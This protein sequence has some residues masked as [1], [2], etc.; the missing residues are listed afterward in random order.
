M[1][2]GQLLIA[3]WR[4]SLSSLLSLFLA[5]VTLGVH[6]MPAFAA[7]IR[8]PQFSSD[9]ASLFF[10]ICSPGKWCVIHV[11]NFETGDLGY[12]QPPPGKFW[13]QASPSKTGH[14]VVFTETPADDGKRNFYDLQLADVQIGI[15]N[16]DGSGR[17]ILT[18]TTGYKQ[19]PNFSRS[20]NQVLFNQAGVIHE[21]GRT[22]IT[23]W[24]LWEV[25]VD[26][27]AI[28]MFA[29]PFEFYVAQ[30]SY[31]VD[32]GPEVL[33]NANGPLAQF[34]ARNENISEYSRRTNNS[35]I[36]SIRRGARAL[37]DPLFMDVSG[38]KIGCMDDQGSVYFDGDHPKKG[39]MIWR[40]RPDGT[41]EVWPPPP[42][43]PDSKSL[44]PIGTTVSPD[45]RHFV[46]AIR[47][48]RDGEKIVRLWM[49]STETGQWQEIIL[50]AS[51]HRINQ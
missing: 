16:T 43:S 38:A 37:D 20:G 50:P 19:F 13:G 47:E 31:Y 6:G 30:R 29:G 35:W 44:T 27:G 34:Q 42:Y 23:K 10:D 4:I 46:M 36:Y 21:T 9:G 11:Y 41:G 22:R 1:R 26:T 18:N 33:V 28:R 24:D 5:F 3:G 39:W 8:D 7:E 45:G 14:K 48:V 15:M 2:E 40:R 51:A 49:L 25:A 32:D 12:Y 17:R